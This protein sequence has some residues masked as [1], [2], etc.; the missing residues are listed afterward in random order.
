[1]P[2]TSFSEETL[3]NSHHSYAYHPDSDRSGSDNSDVYHSESDLSESDLSDPY[4]PNS[5][6]SDL[7]MPWTS[8]HDGEGMSDVL[9]GHTEIILS[10]SS[11]LD[12]EDNDGHQVEAI[13]E[14]A[15]FALPSGV[16]AVPGSRTV[17][18]QGYPYSFYYGG[19]TMNY[20]C[21]AYRRAYC[22]AKL[23]TNNPLERYNRTLNDDFS[24][25]YPDI[26]QLISVIKK[27][28]HENVLMIN[29]ISNRSATATAH[30]EPQQAPRFES[31]SNIVFD[32][33]LE[34]DDSDDFD[35]DNDPEASMSPEY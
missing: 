22:L 9:S 32:T 1:M 35:S 21:S 14:S 6:Q 34:L 4:H 15:G 33:D 16:E 2:E 30:A 20:R 8:S 18:Y 12:V 3:S 19:F 31:E 17:T 28:S 10:Q 23:N 7:N 13:D 25:R 5:N 27:Q 26:I 11:S 24:V 29:D